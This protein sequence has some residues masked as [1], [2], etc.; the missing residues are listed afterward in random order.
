[1]SSQQPQR[2]YVRPDPGRQTRR[3]SDIRESSGRHAAEVSAA[4][5]GGYLSD[6]QVFALPFALVVVMGMVS[7]FRIWIGPDFP[8]PLF[9]IG[10]VCALST[11]GFGIFVSFTISRK[12]ESLDYVDAP[13]V[14]RVSTA[15]HVVEAMVIVVWLNWLATIIDLSGAISGPAFVSLIVADLVLR[16]T[17][18]RL[19]RRRQL[20]ER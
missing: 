4:S 9:V 13:K 16:I 17:R 19:T 6:M 10:A 18:A 5:G 11:L 2:P 15:I 1:M 20:W 12:S 3:V 8:L 14:N 7:A